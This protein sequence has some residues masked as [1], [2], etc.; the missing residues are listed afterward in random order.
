MV[1]LV[2][3]RKLCVIFN[4]MLRALKLPASSSDISTCL[5]VNFMDSLSKIN[6]W[7]K[8][9]PRAINFMAVNHKCVKQDNRRTYYVRIRSGI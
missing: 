8:F 5:S 4:S 7:N 2:K 1:E 6:C 3:V 9:L